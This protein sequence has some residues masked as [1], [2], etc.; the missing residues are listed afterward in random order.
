MHDRV[1]LALTTLRVAV[2]A[3]LFVHGAARWRLGIVDD[4]GVVLGQWG[5][6][7]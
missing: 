4:F 1:G 2:A 5:F 3:L 6:P 7:C